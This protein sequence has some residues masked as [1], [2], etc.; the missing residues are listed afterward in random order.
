M[1]NCVSFAAR[2]GAFDKPNVD[3]PQT[4][5][6]PEGVTPQPDNAPKKKSSVAKKLAIALT[7]AAVVAAGLAIGAKKG[8]FDPAKIADLTKSFKDAKW[9]SWAKKPAKAV[10]EYAQKGGEYVNKG[11]DYVTANANKAVDWAKG[12][13]K[14]APETV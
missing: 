3:A 1:V 6:R 7:T 14:K 5:R 4:Y 2:T 11:V 10:L 8:A 13:F 9:I 12:L